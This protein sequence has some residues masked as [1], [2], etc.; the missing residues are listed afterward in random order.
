MENLNSYIDNIPTE[1]LTELEDEKLT[2]HIDEVRSLLKQYDITTEEDPIM[3]INN[4]KKARI[5]FSELILEIR[6]QQNDLRTLSDNLYVM[7]NNAKELSKGTKP[8]KYKDTQYSTDIFSKMHLEIEE[9]NHK[10]EHI[11]LMSEEVEKKLILIRRLYE[12]LVKNI[13]DY[14]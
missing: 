9:F 4:D 11:I 6:Q 10:S 1:K 12:S 13:Y 2:T 8:F 7:M 3:V 14:V 5:M